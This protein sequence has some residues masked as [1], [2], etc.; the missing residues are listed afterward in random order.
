MGRLKGEALL[1]LGEGKI[2]S[3]FLDWLGAELLI[4][5]VTRINPSA[6]TRPYAQLK[7]GVVNFS[8]NAGIATTDRSIAFETS[9]M[10]LVSS[11]SVNLKTEAIDFSLYPNV[12]SPLGISAGNLANMLRI[13]GTL[14]EPKIGVN[15]IRTMK[16]GVSV[17]AALATGGLSFPA[18]RLA[19]TATQDPH[20]C[21]TALFFKATKKGA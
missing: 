2:S 8:V 14:T 7:C 1:I 9:S 13:Q 11:G 4:M 18:E 6:N 5:V 3:K 16:A 10:T 15:E 12:R 21:R 20:P 19:E 17:G